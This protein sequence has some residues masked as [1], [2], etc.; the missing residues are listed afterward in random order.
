[1]KHF[2]V[3]HWNHIDSILE[4]DISN[5]ALVL[6][7]NEWVSIFDSEYKLV[8]EEWKK[9]KWRLA[10][11]SYWYDP[12]KFLW[13]ISKWKWKDSFQ[14]DSFYPV[15]TEWTEVEV[16]IVEVYEDPTYT[17]EWTI[18]AKMD[19]RKIFFFDPYY[20][21][22][23]EQ[24]KKWEKVKIKISWFLYNV[25]ALKDEEK[26]LKLDLTEERRKE[27]WM[28]LEYD[29]N[30]KLKPVTIVTTEL[31]SYIWSR[32]FYWDFEFQSKIKWHEFI[33]LW[34]VEVLKLELEFVWETQTI[35]LYTYIRTSKINKKDIVDWEPVRWVLYLQ[36]TL[37]EQVETVEDYDKEEY[38]LLRI[39]W[40]AHATCDY[41]KFYDYLANDCVFET[42]W[43]WKVYNWKQE[44]IDFYDNKVKP[45]YAFYEIVKKQISLW[46]VVNQLFEWDEK[47]Y[48]IL[49][50]IELNKS[51]KIKRIIAK[52]AKE[53]DD[54][55]S[56]LL[57]F[58]SQQKEHYPLYEEDNLLNEQELTY[59]AMRYWVDMLES[60]WYEIMNFNHMLTLAP[61][62]VAKKDWVITFFTVRWRHLKVLPWFWTKD[63]EILFKENADDE[64]IPPYVYRKYVA[65]L[66][67]EEWAEYNIIQCHF[68]SKEWK[69]KE[70]WV[71][72]RWEDPACHCILF[73]TGDFDC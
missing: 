40:E 12:I 65:D 51:N 6:C 68:W 3:S 22:N 48:E 28:D 73:E 21:R 62:L 44:I 42:D 30:W 58:S 63:P 11:L 10:V 7:I 5:N 38:H 17:F 19:E 9:E 37:S 15:I 35:P 24:Y 20:F 29:E 23:K 16:E 72:Y 49:F 45:T 31:N 34:W 1:M 57:P 36:W 60:F 59:F 53:M 55:K 70:E 14:V 69:H 8:N 54:Y 67:R 71:L 43:D 26:E 27:M 33:N 4:D 47:L 52:N 66:A 32:E 64:N 18:E 50:C 2:S 41:K 25:S 46:T 61:N 56:F 39:L 13:F